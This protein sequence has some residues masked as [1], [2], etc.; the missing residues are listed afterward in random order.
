MS[1]IA[2]DRVGFRDTDVGIS[3][4]TSSQRSPIYTNGRS[5]G[6]S[7]NS[8]SSNH[9]EAWKMLMLASPLAWLLLE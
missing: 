4:I 5:L 6:S 7:C 1:G 2:T 3:D 9:L 8:L